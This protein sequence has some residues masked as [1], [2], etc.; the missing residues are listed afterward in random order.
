MSKVI[1]LL[2]L[3]LKILICEICFKNPVGST[4]TILTGVKGSQLRGSYIT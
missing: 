3:L 2:V 4:V 1:F